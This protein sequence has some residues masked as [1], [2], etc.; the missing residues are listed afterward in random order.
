[1]ET[2]VGMLVGIASVIGLLLIIGLFVKKSYSFSREITIHTGV[3]QVYDYAKNLKNQLNFNK[4]A[5]QDPNSAKNFEGVDGTVGFIMHWDSADKKVGAGSQEIVRLV[6]NA[7]FEYKMEFIRPF[8]SVAKAV[9]TLT[10]LADNQTLVS[11]SFESEMKYPMNVMLLLMNMEK[12]LGKD[13]EISLKN[14]KNIVEK[15]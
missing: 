10:P 11:W 13:L 8:K 14:L 2:F 9:I 1:M 3:R 4:W 12:M 7:V 6:E 5:M 15:Q